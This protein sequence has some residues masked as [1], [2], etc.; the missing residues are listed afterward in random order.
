MEQLIRY[1]KWIDLF[2]IIIMINGIRIFTGKYTPYRVIKKL[3]GDKLKN[4]RTTAFIGDI[5]LS[6][7][8]YCVTISY[9]LR[10]II[11]YTGYFSFIALF[12]MISGIVIQLIN[13]KK[14]I[15]KLI[16]GF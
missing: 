8:L 7:G 9:N 4:W 6:I 15:G 5:V 14:H 11:S 10:T 3:T 16:A 12:L 13:N 1:F 2:A